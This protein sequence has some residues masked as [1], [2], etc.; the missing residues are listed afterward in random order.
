[1]PGEDVGVAGRGGAGGKEGRKEG[2]GRGS[3]SVPFAFRSLIY[4]RL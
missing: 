1:M 4:V 2:R 3:G